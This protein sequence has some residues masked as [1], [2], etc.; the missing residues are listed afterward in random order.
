MDHRAMDRAASL[1]A[2]PN[3]R[4]AAELIGVSE[5]TVEREWDLARAWLHAEI[6]K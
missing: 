3:I 1:E 5:K 2:Y 6:S 4:A